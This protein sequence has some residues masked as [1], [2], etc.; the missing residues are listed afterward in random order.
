MD[1]FTE[2]AM[3]ESIERY[4]DDYEI[5]PQVTDIQVIECDWDFHVEN[6][7]FWLIS[8]GYTKVTTDDLFDLANDIVNAYYDE[9]A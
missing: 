8:N 1:F 3:Q 4:R 9:V 6:M 2:Q 7:V 5:D